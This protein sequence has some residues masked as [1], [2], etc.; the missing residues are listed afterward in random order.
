MAPAHDRDRARLST[1]R[2]RRGRARPDDESVPA[3]K[4]RGR[5]GPDAAARAIATQLGVTDPTVTEQMALALRSGQTDRASAIAMQAVIGSDGAMGMAGSPG[6][7]CTNDVTDSSEDE[8][9]PPPLPPVATECHEDETR[10]AEYVPRCDQGGEQRTQRR[11]RA[12]RK[13][14]MGNARKTAKS[15]R[16]RS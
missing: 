1:M 10:G 8:E 3:T 15:R 4:N 16:G 5:Q 9:A 12:T 11:R 7:L 6:E 2:D 14:R 13:G